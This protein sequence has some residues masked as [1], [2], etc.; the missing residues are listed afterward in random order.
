VR[1][2]HDRTF[3]L[4]GEPLRKVFDLPG[5]ISRVLPAE[6]DRRLLRQRLSVR[7]NGARRGRLRLPLHFP[8]EVRSLA[9][10]TKSQLRD[11]ISPLPVGG[12][13]N[14][15][16]SDSVVNY[17]HQVLPGGVLRTVRENVLV[18]AWQKKVVKPLPY[19]SWPR[20][21][22]RP[23]WP[24]SPTVLELL[25]MNR[26]GVTAE[27]IQ[28]STYP[29]FNRIHHSEFNS[30]A[31]LRARIIATNVVGI[32]SDI[33]VPAKWLG[34]FRYRL[35]F[36]IL[37]GY[38]KMPVGLVRFLTGQWVRNPHNLWLQDKTSF[39]FYLKKTDRTRFPCIQPG[40]W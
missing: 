35:N 28:Q 4:S 17:V 21:E 2:W 40:P 13:I 24:S 6:P 18:H 27:P 25:E 1:P 8:P 20:L 12:R 36:L 26:R 7:L 10:L 34:Y 22:M 38:R 39:K 3:V 32:R 16:V 33:K 11:A 9:E 15:R 23:A 5:W 29:A 19:S 30:N 31:E 14:Y 37:T